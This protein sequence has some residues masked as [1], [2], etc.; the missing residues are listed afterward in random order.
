MKRI[1]KRSRERCHQDPLPGCSAQ[2]ARNLAEAYCGVCADPGLLVHL[3]LSKVLHQLVV[4][5]VVAEPDV[6]GVWCLVFG[7]GC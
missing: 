7:V 3:E 6:F 2:I 4:F 5:D 1:N